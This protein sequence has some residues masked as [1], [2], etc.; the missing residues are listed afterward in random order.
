VDHDLASTLVDVGED[1]VGAPVELAG[2]LA[3]PRRVA[4]VSRRPS[5]RASDTL[6]F[7]LQAGGRLTV[8]RLESRLGIA[9]EGNVVGHG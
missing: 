3:A 6:Q 1:T 5:V 8:Q 7:L 4:P 9:P 2:R